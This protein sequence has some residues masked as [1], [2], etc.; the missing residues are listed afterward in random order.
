M[1]S[2]HARLDKTIQ[3]QE[4]EISWISST[5]LG[6]GRLKDH[7]TLQFMK[8]HELSSRSD[9]TLR[10][11]QLKSLANQR[12]ESTSTILGWTGR[13]QLPVPLKQGIES[14]SGIP[15]D[16][17]RVHY[18]STKP[19]QLQAHAYAQGTDI[20]LAAGQEHHLPH[21]AWHVVQ[22]KQGRVK[23]TLQLKGVA[24]NDNSDLEHEADVMGARALTTDNSWAPSNPMT[25]GHSISAP[26]VQGVFTYKSKE[27]YRGDIKPA[28]AIYKDIKKKE[29]FPVL[30]KYAEKL[31]AEDGDAIEIESP[32]HLIHTLKTRYG[33]EMKADLL[34]AAFVEEQQ[35][36]V[37]EKLS[38]GKEKIKIKGFGHV[39][40][41]GKHGPD[42]AKDKGKLA[43]RRAKKQGSAVGVW[44]DQDK[45]TS[46]IQAAYARVEGKSGT[47]FFQVA[48]D[49]IGTEFLQDESERAA[50]GFFMKINDAGII[51]TAYPAQAEAVEA[52]NVIKI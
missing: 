36:A 20:H 8:A 39:F 26:V 7:S 29:N 40:S 37:E 13:A 35:S 14:L 46:L 24:I 27:Y 30:L 11:L 1:N 2:K 33:D 43:V 31:A 38:A 22:Q 4:A 47:Y 41:N 50:G 28:T 34:E 16:D 45:A 6:N 9:Q 25:H 23:P 21:E 49:G 3:H 42:M 18:N 15:M 10:L 12:F 19:A 5:A 44:I 17:V 48:L 52:D 51:I 32:D